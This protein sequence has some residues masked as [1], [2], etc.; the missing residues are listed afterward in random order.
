[1]A[2]NV[3]S[4]ESTE[5]FFYSNSIVSKLE[6][7]DGCSPPDSQIIGQP[8]QIQPKIR[9]S[10]YFENYLPDKYVIAVSWPE[11]RVPVPISE[12]ETIPSQKAFLDAVK[13][14]YLKGDVSEPSDENGI[15]EF[16]N[17][18]VNE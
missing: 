13:F 6:I 2:T 12:G 3:D 7:M 16:K 4:V 5:S 1:M 8:F 14:A 11:P 9:V 18:T 10:D 17:L 15:A